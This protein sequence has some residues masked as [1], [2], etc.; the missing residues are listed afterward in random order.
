[1]RKTLSIYLAF[2]GTCEEALGFYKKS[3][4]GDILSMQRFENTPMENTTDAD[5]KKIMHAE[6]KSDDI[7]FMASDSMPAYPITSGNNVT[8]S[9]NF[10]DEKD[11]ETTFNNLAAGGRINMPL[12]D[13]F[14]GAKF[15]MLTD[16]FGINWM[17]NCEK[18]K[19]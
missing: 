7:Y 11:Q 4:G 13:T 16:K 9:L 18:Q 12:Q 17:L 14:W 1:M 8:L 19:K 5:K 6:F 2:P 3:L 10:T 15:G